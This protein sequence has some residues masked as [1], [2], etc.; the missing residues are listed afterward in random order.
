MYLDSFLNLDHD[1]F[2]IN[3]YSASPA[4]IEIAANWGFDFVFI[5]TEHSATG[6]DPTLEKLI[7]AARAAKISPLVRVPDSNHVGLRKAAEMG[8]DGVIVPQVNSASQAAKIIEA[9]KFP[10]LGKR[11]GDSSVRSAVYGSHNFN[12]ADYTQKENQR[13]KVI[14]MAESIE[15]FDHIDAILAIQGIDAIHFGPADFALSR[16]CE[17]DYSM[18]V[19]EIRE[20]VELL[21]AK[22]KEHNVRIMLGCSPTSHLQLEELRLLGATMFLVGNDMAFIN[23]G[24][25]KSHELIKGLKGKKDE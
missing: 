13:C 8:A 17:V 9:V 14:P 21:A 5:D 16:G 1:V 7:L 3:V 12:W 25:A 4:I 6:I 18:K 22:C 19:P 24:C 15:F 10:P 20:A 11:G 23:Q 2:G